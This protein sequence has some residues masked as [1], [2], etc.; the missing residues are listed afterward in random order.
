MK[1]NPYFVGEFDLP[2]HF[3]RQDKS[4]PDIKNFNIYDL[5]FKID[6]IF[7]KEELKIL[8]ST[9]ENISWIPV[10]IDGILK[11]YKNGDKIGSYRASCFEEKLA[12]NLWLKIKNYFP[13]IREMKKDSPTNWD[14]HK[15]WKP[16]GINPLF[17]FIKYGNNCNLVPHYD[18]SFIYNENK[19]TLSTFVI[20][21]TENNTG[22]TRFL[23]DPQ[24]KLPL[25]ERNYEDQF[26]KP[27]NEDIK[28]ISKP[29]TNTGIIFDH[30]ILHDCEPVINETKIIIR[31]DIIY[32]KVL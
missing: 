21:L 19:K 13:T 9:M 4:Q 16:T 23:N 17:R 31:T 7:S 12:Q 14:N 2:K 20:Y 29:I 10:G 32:E 6:N 24:E 3:Y 5:S 18:D 26:F 1:G 27:K 30:R 22:H 8:K 15:L 28:L 11:N 25:T